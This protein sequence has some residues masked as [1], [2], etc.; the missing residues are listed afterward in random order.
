MMMALGILFLIVVFIQWRVI[1]VLLGVDL[2]GLYH[3]IR[4]EKL[5]KCELQYA[6]YKLQ[7]L[8]HETRYSKQFICS[9]MYFYL[10]FVDY[11]PYIDISTPPNKRRVCSCYGKNE[12]ASKPIDDLA[13]LHHV[14]VR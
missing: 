10:D 14:H 2:V 1:V 5:G 12:M 6:F 4:A 13:P 7:K 3:D 8:I 9:S 11:M